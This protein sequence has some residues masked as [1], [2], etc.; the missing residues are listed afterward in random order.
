MLTGICPRCQLRRVLVRINFVPGD[1]KAGSVHRVRRHDCGPLLEPR[2][3]QSLR[4][5]SMTRLTH[6]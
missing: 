4:P 3:V 1:P 6:V 5:L 2:D